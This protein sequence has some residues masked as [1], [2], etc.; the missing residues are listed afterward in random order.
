MRR[1]VARL[2]IIKELRAG[3]RWLG[4]SSKRWAIADLTVLGASWAL[5]ESSRTNT[6]SGLIATV[7][8]TLAYCHALWGV[9]ISSTSPRRAYYRLAMFQPA[10]FGVPLVLAV[11]LLL[12]QAFPHAWLAAVACLAVIPP[13]R[14]RTQRCRRI[15]SR[16]QRRRS[17]RA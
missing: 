6:A 9:L 1:Q 8:F 3:L 2:P 17:A 5:I 12:T 14:L 10:H 7:L 4:A 13:D 16:L 11:A 15:D